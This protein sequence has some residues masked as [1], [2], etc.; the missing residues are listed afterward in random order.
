[1]AITTSDEGSSVHTLTYT[2]TL[3]PFFSA[4]TAAWY[5]DLPVGYLL[6]ELRD[7]KTLAELCRSAGRPSAPLVDVLTRG[8]VELFAAEVDGYRLTA[9]HRRAIEAH[10]RERITALVIG[11]AGL[12]RAA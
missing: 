10:L 6:T 2:P 4:E 11:P 3:D 12:G 1:M 7:G 5:L 9:A 8:A